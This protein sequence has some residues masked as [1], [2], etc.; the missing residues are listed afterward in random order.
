MKVVF[1]LAEEA[2]KQ[3]GI[4][5]N[6]D[7]EVTLSYEDGTLLDF[8]ESLS[9]IPENTVIKITEDKDFVEGADK[10]LEIDD[11]DS[12]V[13]PSSDDG[14]LLDVR[15]PLSEIQKNILK[16]VTDDK[17]VSEG[18]ESETVEILPQ[19]LTTHE[20]DNL[21]MKLNDMFSMTLPEGLT[22]KIFDVFDNKTFSYETTEY[23]SKKE[24]EEKR[25]KDSSGSFHAGFN[26][27]TPEISFEG[28]S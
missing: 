27:Q 19:S 21:R 23:A 15:K 2:R 26:T 28:K 3:F 1:D 16:K 12:E 7:S 18:K 24:L 5:E 11:E 20:L 4:V 14:Q 25:S 22:L 9:V 17:E 6:E 10:H 8:G 13:I